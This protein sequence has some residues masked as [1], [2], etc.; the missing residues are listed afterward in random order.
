MKNKIMMICT[1]TIMLSAMGAYAQDPY[2][3]DKG[4]QVGGLAKNGKA[5]VS[6]FVSWIL[7]EPEDEVLGPM[8][9]AWKQ[10][11]SHKPLDKGTTILL[12]EKNGYFR[13]DVDYDKKYEGE[14]GEPSESTLYVE[15]VVWNCAD[16]QH[17]VLAENVGGTHKG[18]PMAGGQYD[19]IFFY[20]YEK[21]TQR[22]FLLNDAIDPKE[23]Q[24]LVPSQEWQYDGKQYYY[25]I[26][27]N[28]G[29][30]KKMSSEEFDQWLND[31]PVVVLSLP[32]IGKNIKA[33]IVTTTGTIE[34]ELVWDGYRFHLSK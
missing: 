11:L 17:K 7:A 13:Y 14:E 28:T 29:Q 19:G 31:R 6:E 3:K 32:R 20:L 23:I 22:I 21:A 5:T 25:A 2:E 34:K 15:L 4:Y 9:R 27:Y 26:D 24:S 1:A 16:G 8:S 10:Y 33:S 30:K 18:K 12:D